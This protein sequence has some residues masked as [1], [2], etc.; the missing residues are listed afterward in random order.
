MYVLYDI[1]VNWGKSLVDHHLPQEREKEL[2]LIR[3]R[4]QK[5]DNMWKNKEETAD[6]KKN[7]DTKVGE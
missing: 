1:S 5:A 7:M 3:S 2:A 4:F 6:A